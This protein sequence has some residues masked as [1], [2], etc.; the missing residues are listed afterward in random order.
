MVQVVGTA[1]NDALIGSNGDDLIQGLAGDDRLSVVQAFIN[2]PNGIVNLGD[3]GNDTLDGGVGNDTM[4]G[5]IGN[6]TYIVDSVGDTV[7]EFFG[8]VIDPESGGIIEGGNDTVRASVG[9]TLSNFVENL[10]LTG[11][12]KINGTGNELNNAI[13]GN[14]ANNTLNGLAG[15]DTLIG[16]NGVDILNGGAGNDQLSGGKGNDVLVGGAGADR[17]LFDSG[18][19][20][21]RSDFGVDTIRDFVTGTDKIVLDQTT[22]GNIT[23][24]DIEIVANDAIAATSDALISFSLGSDRVFFNQNGVQTGFGTG[25]AFV[26]LQGLPEITVSDFTIQV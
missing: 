8:S 25:G 2:Q 24:N 5:G 15:N 19:S 17:F 12:A 16:G 11:T 1:G 6:D 4:T 26:Q 9:F 22:F 20:F 23:V 18:K 21:Q 10:T 3:P 13:R 7:I 14:G